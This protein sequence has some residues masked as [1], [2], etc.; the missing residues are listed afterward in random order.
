MTELFLIIK[1]LWLVWIWHPI[2]VYLGLKECCDNPE[3]QDKISTPQYYESECLN[4]GNKR[5]GVLASPL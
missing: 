4:C 3:I 2:L 5:I 1:V